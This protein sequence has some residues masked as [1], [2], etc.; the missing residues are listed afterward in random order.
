M[1]VLDGLQQLEGVHQAGVGTVVDLR[2]ET[3]GS[4]SPAAPILVPG[5][6]ERKAEGVG[7]RVSVDRMLLR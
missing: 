5:A 6:T 2:L 1:L 4:V 7:S 3:D